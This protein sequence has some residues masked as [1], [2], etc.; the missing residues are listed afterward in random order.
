MSDDPNDLTSPI[1]EGITA[2]DL[3]RTLFIGVGGVGMNGLTRLYATR[4]L[5]VTGSETKDWPTLPELERL[6][7]TL[8]REHVVSNLD[9]IDTV[10]RS[11]AINDQHLEVVEARRRGIPVLHRSEAIAAA[12]TGRRS[13]V[14]TGTHG[15]TTT[16]AIITQMLEHAGLAP[17]YVNGG[18]N[19]GAHTGAHGNG[20]YFV[21]EADESDRSFL[22]F[23][24]EI[25][26][27]TNIDVDH[28][29]TYGDMESLTEAFE[30]FGRNTD[31][32]GL[33]VLCADN[34]GTAAL[35]RKFRAEGR[36]VATYGFSDG[37]DIQLGEVESGKDGVDYTVLA[38]N[39]LLGRF[40]LPMPG[41]HIALNSAA[42]IAV[43]LYIG[44]EPEAVAEGIAAF[45]GVKR[46]FEKRGEIDGYSVFDEY[47]YHPTA[48]TEAIKTLKEVAAP[49]RL[50]VVF[51]PY[52]VYRTVE[53]RAD[54]AEALSLADK[55]VVMEIFGPG[56]TIPE[57]EGGQALLDAVDLPDADKAFVA[58]WD[59][60]PAAV[61]ALAG[62]GDVVVTMG[63]PPVQLMPEDLLR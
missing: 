56:E 59:D 61:K 24:P 13:I 54:I 33:L 35:A 53:M 30:R 15:K 12:M 58:E 32:D 1:D 52:R 5:A 43:G 26:I 6:G 10:V 41:K 63:A 23:R 49:G 55:A 34:P 7:V 57:G 39:Q 8:H 20:E 19:I 48:M 9:G 38:H 18:E 40:H 28:L 42:A 45:G 62:E 16:T 11:T 21:A 47:A 31:K 60:V 37:A 51:M 22:R 27:I 29:N 46:R 25:G 17:S 36:T 4:G 50:I 2:E 14:V 3:G 44:L